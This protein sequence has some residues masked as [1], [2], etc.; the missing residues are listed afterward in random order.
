MTVTIILGNR[1]SGKSLLATYVAMSDSC[2]VMA[3]YKIKIP[4]W[5]PLTPSNI[6]EINQP[7]HMIVDESYMEFNSTNSSSKKNQFWQTLLFQSRKRKVDITVVSQLARRVDINFRDLAEIVILA[8]NLSD[9]DPTGETI[10]YP[11]FGYT[12]YVISDVD[13]TD[14]IEF[15]LEGEEAWKAMNAYDSDERI[16]ILDDDLLAMVDKSVL[17][18]KVDALADQIYKE[19]NGRKLTKAVITDYLTRE[20]HGKTI[21]DMVYNRYQAL[22]S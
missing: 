13:V 21:I 17:L 15:T 4:N 22:T 11:R 19:N 7:T 10:V 6:M 12:A 3:N 8:R 2:Q 5:R 20:G 16:G 9:Y 1:G 14:P 18:P